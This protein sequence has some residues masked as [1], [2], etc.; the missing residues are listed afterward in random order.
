VNQKLI[1][2]QLSN[3]H[4]VTAEP[5]FEAQIQGDRDGSYLPVDRRTMMLLSLGWTKP[6]KSVQDAA[7]RQIG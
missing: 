3:F 7:G 1:M 2:G 5:W 4:T 6:W